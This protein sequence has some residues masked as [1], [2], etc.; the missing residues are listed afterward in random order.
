MI[1]NDLRWS[2]EWLKSLVF[3][4]GLSTDVFKHPFYLVMYIHVH[5][6]SRAKKGEGVKSN[7]SE[8]GL[9]RL[10]WQSAQFPNRQVVAECL[11][12]QQL[13]Y[14]KLVLPTVAL[15]AQSLHK[16]YLN[17]YMIVQQENI[18]LAK[19]TVVWMQHWNY[20]RKKC[21]KRLD[22]I[23][24]AQIRLTTLQI[25]SYYDW[26]KFRNQTSDN[27]DRWKSRGGKSQRGEEKKRDQRVRR[28]K[29]QVREKV[30]KL[31]IQMSFRVADAR[32]CA[33]CQ[34]WAKFEGSAAFP[35]TT[36]GVGHLKRTCKD[37][38]SVGGAVQETCSSLHM[39]WHHVA[40][41]VL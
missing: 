32:D 23:L 7:G 1:L 21:N 19:Q 18:F 10:L 39:T 37:A 29:M 22:N 15:K 30:G 26:T 13:Q 33:P 6:C 41:A 11:H 3:M 28:K 36:A 35:R 8:S 16:W 5:S 4:S 12:H 25:L 14:L 2:Q 31:D 17:T 20:V 24:I 9:I 27:M 40:G 38:F 34:K